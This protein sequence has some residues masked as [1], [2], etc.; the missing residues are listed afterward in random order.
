M[1]TKLGEGRRRMLAGLSA[2]VAVSSLPR[3][4]LA[5][6][7][8]VGRLAP[9]FQ[10]TTLDGRKHHLTDYAGDV[11]VLNIWATWCGPCKVELPLLD[12][13]YRR[14][15]ATGLHV[16]ALNTEDSV[17]LSRLE[18]LAA[19]LAIPMVRDLRGPYETLGGVPTNYVIDRAGVLRWAKADAFDAEAIR[20]I[21]IPL[22][23]EA[24]PDA[25]LA[26]TVS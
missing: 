23:R 19:V 26:A 1:I 16:F 14:L 2:A 25:G 15:K 11:V 24:G 13:Y 22:L 4:A 8:V 21:I 20:A 9:E 10:V 3:A 18:P 5:S 17:P 6:T 7:P 12:S